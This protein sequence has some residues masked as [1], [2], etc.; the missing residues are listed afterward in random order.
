MVLKTCGITMKLAWTSTSMQSAAVAFVSS[1]TDRCGVRPLGGSNTS[2]VNHA[3]TPGGLY[4]Q[5]KKSAEMNGD[6]IAYQCLNRTPVAHTYSQLLLD[7]NKVRE[8]KVRASH[9]HACPRS[10]KS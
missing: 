6:K 10:A 8:L 7:V 9:S 3:V 4:G 5:L 1:L 2:R